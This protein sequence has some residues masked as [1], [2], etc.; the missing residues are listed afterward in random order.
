[1]Q[2][3]STTADLAAVCERL[4]QHAYVAVDTEFMRETTFWPKLCLIQMAGPDLEAIVDPLAKGIDLNPFFEL[5]GNTAVTKVF[6][7]ARQDVEIVWVMGRTIPKPMF[8]SQV[9]AMVCGFGESISY[10]NLVKQIT[11]A[12]LD[13]SSRFTDWARRP[14]STKQLQYALG[15][16]T[17]LRDVYLRLKADL[18]RTERAS[19]LEEEM[20]LLSDPR[21]YETQPEDSWRRVKMKVRGRKAQAVLIELAAWRERQAQAQDVPRNRILRDEVLVDIATHMP[22]DV[23]ALGDLRSLSDGFARSARAKDIVDAVNAGLARDPKALP[24]QEQVLIVPPDKLAMVEL[25]K[26][27]LKGNAARHGVAPRLIAD[28]SDIERIVM[29]LIPD[30]PA[31]RGWRREMFGADA[32]MVKEGRLAITVKSGQIVT[33]GLGDSLTD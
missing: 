15:D 7:A 13:K 27:L 28:T 21:S 24:Q 16:V 30:V 19:W 23:T 18:E 8:D 22:T 1:M 26:V 5:M 25:L 3:I 2:I 9:A 14:L 20:A 29:E 11:K 31:M 4:A 10:V 32:L 33:V 12:D 6:H 17:H